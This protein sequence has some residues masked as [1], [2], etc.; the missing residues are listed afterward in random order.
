MT[1]SAFGPGLSGIPCVEILSIQ[2]LRGCAALMIVIFHS[3][4]N[5][6]GFE[7]YSSGFL[8]A[9]VDIFFVISGFIMWVTTAKGMTML[10]FFR[11]R[12]IRIVP[13]Y[14]LLTTVVLATLCVFPNAV[15]SGRFDRLHVLGSYLFFP[16]VHPILGI[17][18]PLLIPGWTLNYEMFFYAIFGVA[19]ILPTIPRLVAVSTIL[20]ALVSLPLLTTVPPLTVVEFYTFS[21]ILEFAFGMALGWLYVGGAKLSPAT[22]WVSLL[23]GAGAIATTGNIFVARGLW[24]GVPALLV[25]TG[26]VMIERLSGL[27]NIPGLHFLGNASY[28]LYLSH[29]IV[30]SI[31]R[32]IWRRFS[33]DLFPGAELAYLCL[34]VASAVGVAA[35]IYRY[36]EVPM[37]RLGRL[38]IFRAS[39][40][41]PPPAKPSRAL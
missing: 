34:C 28:S 6:E 16:V 19:L 24:V 41:Q 5:G 32:Q 30:V 13:L 20:F 21:R 9:G 3:R 17:M 31:V 40:P 1:R 7:G 11:R 22:A 37:L 2:Y 8:Q 12:F 25:V 15:Q 38:Q 35:L 10:E 23:L 29:P 18:Q 4:L 33:L 14:W 26:A 36:I 27:P 39:V